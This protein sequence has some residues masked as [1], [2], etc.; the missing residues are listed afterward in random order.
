[1]RSIPRG[2]NRL[3]SPLAMMY[4]A[5]SAM[6][7]IVHEELLENVPDCSDGQIGR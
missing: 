6:A 4:F 3:L 1:M 7:D 2:G 5:P